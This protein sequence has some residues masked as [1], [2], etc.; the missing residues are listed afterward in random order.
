MTLRLF[1]IQDQEIKWMAKLVDHHQPLLKS[2]H[3]M[4]KLRTKNE[5]DSR[6]VLPA[7]VESNVAQKF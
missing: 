5:K 1:G 2:S 4:M 6:Q 7:M 3:N